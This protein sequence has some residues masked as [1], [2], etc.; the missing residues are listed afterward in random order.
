MRIAI[1]GRL[2][3]QNRLEGLG[4]FT[5]E[6]LKRMVKLYP[7]HDYLVLFDRKPAEELL[8]PGVEFRIL[9]PA[10]RHPV[11]YLLWFE[12]LVPVHL[13]MWDAE[14]FVSFDGFT[15]QH[16]HIPVVTVIH[17]LAYIHYSEHMKPA[18]LWYYKKYQP[19]FARRSAG[20]LT[21]SEYSA[22]DIREQYDMD[23]KKI[24]VVY[25]GSR[26]EQS[27]PED[28]LSV[29]DKYGITAN[30]YFIYTGS[31]HPRKNIARLVEAFEQSSAANEQGA[32]LVLAGRQAWM[33]QDIMEHIASSPL[34]DQIIH[35][36]YITDGEMWNLLKNALSLCYVSLFEGFGVPVLDAFH[37]DVPVICSSTT[38]VKEVAGEAGL[39]VNPEDI[40]AISAAMDQIYEDA[41]LR[42]EL[43]R[44]GGERKHRFSWTSTTRKVFQVIEETYG[45]Y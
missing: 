23:N 41:A 26:F 1:N 13:R 27:P 33:T 38:S 5:W 22:G 25:N 12:V 31:I 44:K 45:E 14:V 24:E 17:D 11:L 6:V 10:A 7:E 39:L 34:T 16:L 32:K 35:T 20:L 28:N 19:K 15:S 42:S 8:I 30:D 4:Y 3:I 9:R 2:L 29:L 21:V 18:D 36:G 40:Q 37:A 43:I